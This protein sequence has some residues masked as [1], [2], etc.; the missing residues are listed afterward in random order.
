VMVF[1]LFHGFGLATKLQEF[2][3]SPNGLVTNIVSFNA[4]VEIGQMLALTA[5]LIAISFWRTRPGFL[6]H[7]FAANTIIMTAGFML[8]GSQLARYFQTSTG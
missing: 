7:S 5:I 8:V 6:R 1:G 4:G 2:T 3:L